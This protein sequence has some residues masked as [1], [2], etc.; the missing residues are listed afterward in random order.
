MAIQMK[1]YVE[2][3]NSRVRG[4]FNRLR[5]NAALEKSKGTLKIHYTLSDDSL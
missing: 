5:L 2:K 4:T 3:K 1:K